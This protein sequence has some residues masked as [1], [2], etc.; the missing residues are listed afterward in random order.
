MC[1]D[2]V[3]DAR[4]RCWRDGGECGLVC[5]CVWQTQCT[6][7][8]VQGAQPDDNLVFRPPCCL[9]QVLHLLT[10]ITRTVGGALC[11]LPMAQD[12]NELRNS[13]TSPR[14]LHGMIA[15]LASIAP[16]ARV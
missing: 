13:S 8:P 9:V 11:Q 10:R 7:Y 4:V 16:V 6:V 14:S 5:V 12:P 3:D 15:G 2:D 1:V